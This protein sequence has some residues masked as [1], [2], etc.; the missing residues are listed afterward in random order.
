MKRQIRRGVFETNSSSTH[1]L[2]MMLKTDYERWENEGLL[3][4]TGSGR[5]WKD[6]SI[7]P[8]N[9]NLYTK[10]EV[11]NFIKSGKYYQETDFA[12]MSD[13]ELREYFKEADFEYSDDSNDD[14]EGFYEEFTTPSGDTVV[15]FGEYG[16]EG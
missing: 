11:I 7:A 4:Y 1:S 9:N 10:E 16:Y 6:K 14:L 8:K 3:L 12:T 2:T 5:C 15:A 13:E